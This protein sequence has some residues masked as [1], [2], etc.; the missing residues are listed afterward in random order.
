MILNA[1]SEI[2]KAP[3]KEL[4]SHILGQLESDKWYSTQTL[5]YSL[6]AIANTI[7]Q[8]QTEVKNFSFKFDGKSYE[9]ADSIKLPFD[10]QKAKFS[11]TSDFPL[12]INHI[13]DG[14][15]LEKDIAAR[16]EKIALER[17]FLDEN[18]KPLDVSTLDSAKSFYLV[19]R[20]KN[21]DENTPVSVR[22][23]AIT[24]NLPS[25]WEIENIRLNDDNLPDFV[26]NDSITYTDIRDDKIMWFLD[27]NS[28]SRKMFVKINTITPGNYLL[29]PATA[30]AM[31]DNSFRA[32]TTAMPVIVK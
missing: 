14:I 30:E 21:A 5:G 7:P 1:F 17:E 23:V 20:L 29:P 25:G 10:S 11:S 12:Y 22:N 24:Q 32:N 28:Q 16:A 26:R 18:G 19:L 31:Y 8:E 6:L 9:S 4:L 27:F 2:Y 3:H 15:L 13:R